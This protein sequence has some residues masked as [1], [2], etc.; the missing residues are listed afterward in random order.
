MLIFQSELLCIPQGPAP[1]DPFL[2]KTTLHGD[3][4][5]Q[6]KG[7]RRR[8]CRQRLCPGLR[9]GSSTDIILPQKRGDRELRR[10]GKGVCLT[11]WTGQALGRFMRR[12]S[13]P[14]G[15]P[16]LRSG[17]DRVSCHHDS[18]TVQCGSFWPHA[19]VYKVKW[20]LQFRS[21]AS[22]LSSAQ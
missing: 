1:D 6:Q 21:C 20:K 2:R 16:S 22:G 8:P 10:E 19:A 3:K 5:G 17:L 13:G 15:N 7:P 12:Q 11:G 18:F 14:G 4:A 9:A